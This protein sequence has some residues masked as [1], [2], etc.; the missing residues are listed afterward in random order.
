MRY[1]KTSFLIL[2][3]LTFVS[4]PVEASGN[5][6]VQNSIQKILKQ[7]AKCDKME[8][9]IKSLKLAEIG[10]PAVSYLVQNLKTAKNKEK[11]VII[12][13][14]GEMED[15]ENAKIIVPFLNDKSTEARVITSESLGLLKSSDAVDPLLERLKIESDEKVK[16]AIIEA[17]GKAGDKKCVEPLIELLNNAPDSMASAI[18]VALRDYKDSRAIEPLINSLNN[19]GY[20]YNTEIAKT[21][22]EIGKPAV[23]PLLNAAFDKKRRTEGH[24][25]A[26]GY[27]KTSNSIGALMNIIKQGEGNLSEEE[28]IALYAAGKL[29]IPYLR[30]I[31]RTEKL[32]DFSAEKL[33]KIGVMKKFASNL[34]NQSSVRRQSIAEILGI[35]KDKSA[36]FILVDLLNDNNEYVRKEAVEALGRIGDK[37][38]VRHLIPLLNDSDD[39]LKYNVIDALGEIKSKDAV[40][41]LIRILKDENHPERNKAAYALGE[42]GDKRA[43][44]P[45]IEAVD[46][47]KETDWMIIYAIGETGDKRAVKPLLKLLKTNE[48]KNHILIALGK[49]QDPEAFDVL[50]KYMGKNINTGSIRGL[51]SLSQLKDKR[52]IQPMISFIKNTKW[53]E[54]KAGYQSGDFRYANWNLGSALA[55]FG[56]PALKPVLGLLNDKNGQVRFIAGCALTEIKDPLAEK[57][58]LKILKKHDIAVIAGSSPYLIS[59]GKKEAEV[60]LIESLNEYGDFYMTGIFLNSKNRRLNKA[61]R[62]HGIKHKLCF[63]CMSTLVKGPEWGKEWES[64]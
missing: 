21:L 34:K 54:V 52:A 2:L 28:K 12:Q 14:L 27:M 4:M 31:L 40:E 58:L 43:L 61:A 1:L 19:D 57:I 56:K 36:T 48:D 37:K 38:A 30:K 47:N 51:D 15:K 35:I 42:I 17:M 23:K 6:G 3:L 9:Y 44:V 39:F 24:I 5:Q 11:V 55:N 45:L 41:P 18:A 50:L 26:L 8:L 62:I 16:L 32:K 63:H 25:I 60:P 46:F 64:K 7:T 49:I 10:K 59:K 29:S 20:Y 33:E 13:A 22:A 53:P